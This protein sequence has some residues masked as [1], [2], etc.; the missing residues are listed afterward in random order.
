MTKRVYFH[1][2]TK[3]LG[4]KIRNDRPRFTKESILKK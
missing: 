1:Y 3:L 2:Y 4:F